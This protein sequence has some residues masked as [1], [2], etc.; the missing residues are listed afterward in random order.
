VRDD[1]MEMGDVWSKSNL[2]QKQLWAVA[3]W[4]C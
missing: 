4:Q 2:V 1:P 3:P